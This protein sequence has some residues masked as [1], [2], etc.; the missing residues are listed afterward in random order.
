MSNSRH[1]VDW[2]RPLVCVR[3]KGHA[4]EA[5]P[6][7][8]LGILHGNARPH[9]IAVQEPQGEFVLWVDATG[10]VYTDQSPHLGV[11]NRAEA[12]DPAYCPRC[13]SRHIVKVAPHETWR[14]AYGHKF[15]TK[16]AV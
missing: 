12:D 15:V 14:C 4:L 11:M 3:D 8:R 2:S 10:A 7:R 5:L 13:E 16:E 1:V 6:A 9:V